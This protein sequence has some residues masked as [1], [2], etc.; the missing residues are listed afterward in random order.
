MGLII[1]V[2]HLQRK[3]GFEWILSERKAHVV[4]FFAAFL[5]ITGGG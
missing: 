2:K 1:L 4:A 5:D 3:M